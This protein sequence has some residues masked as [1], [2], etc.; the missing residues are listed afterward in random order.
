MTW[1]APSRSAR[2]TRGVGGA[3]ALWKSEV[4]PTPAHVARS[5]GVGDR[6]K[7]MPLRARAV[8]FGDMFLAT[9][10]ISEFEINP[11]I[12]RRRGEGLSAVDALVTT[13]PFAPPAG[14]R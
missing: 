12:V 8:R 13:V 10:D 7:W 2:A 3:R 5:A 9:A 11:V 6:R 4:E 1:Y 14:S